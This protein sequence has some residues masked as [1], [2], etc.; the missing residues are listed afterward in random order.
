MTEDSAAERLARSRAEIGYTRAGVVCWGWNMVPGEGFGKGTD[1]PGA[2]RARPRGPSSSRPNGKPPPATCPPAPR[3]LSS[4]R[5]GARGSSPAVALRPHSG[6]R[7]LPMTDRLSRFRRAAAVAALALL[8]ACATEAGDGGGDGAASAG[9]KAV[10]EG[11]DALPERALIAV[12]PSAQGQ[13]NAPSTR[14]VFRKLMEWEAFWTAVEGCPVRPIPADVDWEK[15]MVVLASMGKRT[16]S[17]EGISIIGSGQRGDTLVVLV[18]RSL[19]PPQCP[20]Q[21][22]KNYPVAVARFPRNDGRV[23]FLEERTILPCG[24]F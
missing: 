7:A 17:Q 13:C 19:L 16:S 8:A 23:R 1:A 24:N 2:R 10:P 11:Y 21:G 6:S 14:T 3:P 9:E 4:P 15:E 22:E 18:R 12:T 20:D 5:S